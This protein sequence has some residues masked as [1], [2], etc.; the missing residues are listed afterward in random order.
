[1]K[2]KVSYTTSFENIPDVV[3]DIVKKNQEI[4]DRLSDL[5]E[6]MQLGDLG[7]K[8]LKNFDQMSEMAS[9]LVEGYSDCQAILSGYLSAAFAKPEEEEQNDGDA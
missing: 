6:D 5:S 4:L 1:M 9:T 7:L 2:V 8:S 3:K